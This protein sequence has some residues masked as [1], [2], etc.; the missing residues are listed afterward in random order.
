MSIEHSFLAFIIV[1]CTVYLYYVNVYCMFTVFDGS[2]FSN[3]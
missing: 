3:E 1:Q 2:E